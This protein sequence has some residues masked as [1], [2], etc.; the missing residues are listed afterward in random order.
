MLLLAIIYLGYICL[1]LPDS[2]F[3][4]AWPVIHTDF[5]I[6]VSYAG[7]ITVTVYGTTILSSLMTDKVTR[8]LGT[9]LVTAISV[10]LT[11]VALLGFAFS[12]NFWLLLLFAIPMG[13]GAGGVDASLNNYMAIHY[14]S[15]FMSW[16]HCFWGIGAIISPYIMSFWLKNDLQWK[17]GYL[18]VGILQ[19]VLTA[20]LFMSLPLWK[21]NTEVSE[22]SSSSAPPLTYSQIF[23]LKGI[24]SMLLS[25][26]A[27]CAIEGI[28]FSWTSSYL[29]SGRGMSA[30][31]GAK[32]AA[33]FYFGMTIGRLITGF[34]ANKVGD[35]NMTR[36]G[37]AIGL[38]GIGMILLPVNSDALALVGLFVFG[39]GCGPIFPALM[40]STPTIY[41]T[42]KSQSIVGLQ[43][44]F[45]YMGST[46]M[47]PV[48]GIAAKHIGTDLYPFFIMFFMIMTVILTENLNIKT[49][50]Q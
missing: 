30:E 35:K 20:I 9:G 36:L 26:T 18:T 13:L 48:F 46:L 2:L 37:W 42:D 22:E 49:K 32:Y 16:L 31:D 1:G 38:T 11:A 47:P 45:G 24:V 10:G 33:L 3:G 14:S 28:A 8:K 4:P 27:Y 34:F 44:A 17:N 7:F 23:R 12:N 21:K 6:P 40:H 29:V 50:H 15:K 39:F 25:F 43:M 5:G 41:G 19:S